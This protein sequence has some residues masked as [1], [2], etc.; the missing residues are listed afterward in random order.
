[1]IYH[2]RTPSPETTLGPIRKDKMTDFHRFAINGR[3][4]EIAWYRKARYYV[5]TFDDAKDAPVS[6]YEGRPHHWDAVLQSAERECPSP[7]ELDAY[8]ADALSREPVLTETE[9]RAQVAAEIDVECPAC[10]GS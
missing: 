9:Y 2:D 7:A 6:I 10:H 1:M 5:V 4:G 3:E 8:V